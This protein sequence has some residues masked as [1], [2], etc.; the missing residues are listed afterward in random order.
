[1]K[2]EY[3]VIV[4]GSGIGG[5][6]TA[7]TVASRGYSVAVVDGGKVGGTCVN[8]GCVPTKYLLRVSELYSDVVRQVSQGIF[9]G[10]IHPDIPGI[11]RRKNELI[12]QVIQWYVQLVFPSYG[13]DLIQEYAKLITPH[14][15]RLRNGTILNAR[16][17]IVVATGSK[18]VIPPVNGLREALQNGCAITSNEALSLNETPE[19]LL[20]VGA[21]PI[22]L[23][24]ASVWR[25]LGSEI[26]VVELMDRILPNMDPDISRTL[27]RI[28]IDEKGFAI[29]TST[30]VKE[31]DSTTCRANISS[32]G[33]I[34]VDKI[35]VATGR[36]PYS[37]GLG[38]NTI[39]VRRGEK[40]EILV[41]KRQETNIKG[42]YAVGDVTGDPLLASKAKVQGIVAGLNIVGEEAEYSPLVVAYTVFTDPE[43]GSVG[44]S[45]SK[46]DP[47]FIVKKFPATVNYRA[48]VNEKMYG[49]AKIV[50]EKNTEKV[51]GFH[52][53]GMYAS[54]IVNTA[55]VAIANG[56]TLNELLRVLFTHPVMSE[57]FL[58]TAHLA[59]GLNVYL[60]RR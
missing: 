20:V 12:D 31:I 17:A 6:A 36:R 34:N 46:K 22:G 38:L 10:D 55:A 30:A 16:K 3:D 2:R 27:E 33:W 42:I 48:I 29:H 5:A 35:L 28:L 43:A 23:E 18:P 51:V 9:V 14:S 47:R 39:G 7:L 44:V 52:M 58:D 45:A 54:E 11:M 60:P 26:I 57:V 21:G 41:N 32:V 59:K 24:L 37:D 4:I 13:I 25:N 1:M 49:I 15:I 53:V 40:G 8:V 56:I 19:R 50:A